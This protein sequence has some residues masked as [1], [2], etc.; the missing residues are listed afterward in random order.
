MLVKRMHVLPGRILSTLISIVTG[1]AEPMF[2]YLLELFTHLSKARNEKMPSRLK[3]NYCEI[4]V[5]A[6]AKENCGP[7]KIDPLSAKHS[8]L[9]RMFNRNWQGNFFTFPNC[10]YIT[11]LR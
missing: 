7:T 10:T 2:L 1:F 5:R 9:R 6:S 11:R 8:L 4:V 3:R